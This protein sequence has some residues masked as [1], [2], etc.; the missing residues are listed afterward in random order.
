MNEDQAVA[1]ENQFEPWVQ[2]DQVTTETLKESGPIRD[3]KAA[4]VRKNCRALEVMG[5][6]NLFD[7]F[8]AHEIHCNTSVGGSFQASASLRHL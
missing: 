1:E 7:P 8:S 4:A 6:Q 5:M 2:V 3:L